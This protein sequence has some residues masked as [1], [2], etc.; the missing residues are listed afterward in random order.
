MSNTGCPILEVVKR[1]RRKELSN[2]LSTEEIEKVDTLC[3]HCP[4]D[5]CVLEKKK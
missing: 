2:K 4:L 3:L 5:M 1:L